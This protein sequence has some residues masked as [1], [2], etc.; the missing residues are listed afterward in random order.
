MKKTQRLTRIAPLSAAKMFSIIYG[1]LGLI[2][3]IFLSIAAALGADVPV[4][5]GFLP[6]MPVFYAF[7]GF[8]GGALVA[9]I[10]NLAATNMGGIEFET[11]DDVQP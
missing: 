9:A 3:A 6:I 8:L 11:S 7:L 4:A 5:R 1:A 10:Y 2:G